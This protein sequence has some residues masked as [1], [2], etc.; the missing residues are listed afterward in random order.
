MDG[1]CS[2]CGERRAKYKVFRGEIWGEKYYLEDIGV[3]QKD[4][5]K[6]DFK[7]KC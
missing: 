4:N 3:R 5:I 2:T 1:A 6:M 7:Q